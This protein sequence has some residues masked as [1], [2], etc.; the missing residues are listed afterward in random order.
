[1]LREVADRIVDDKELLIIAKEVGS[2]ISKHPEPNIAKHLSCVI[3]EDPEFLCRARG[4]SVIVCAALIERD[5]NH[6]F[7]VNKALGLNTE[8]K[9]WSFFQQYTR[10]FL[11]TMVPPV[12]KYGF[13]FESHPQNTM[14]RFKKLENSDEFKLIGFL[15][16]DFDGIDYH[17]ETIAA[18]TG[19]YLKEN[20]HVREMS[21]DRLHAYA[22]HGIFQSHLLRIVRAL[23]FHYCGRGWAFVRSVLDEML[24]ESCRTRE[25]WLNTETIGIMSYV[26]MNHFAWRVL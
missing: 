4:E 20:K 15:Y 24:P 11:K 13:C 26:V 17:I 16:R 25:L 5:A 6:E 14:A 10:L 7:M 21:I 19:I 8:A 18:T 9:R 3:R 2:V 23:G 22:F 1:M 12:F